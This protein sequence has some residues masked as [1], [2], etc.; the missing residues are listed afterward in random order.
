[1]VSFGLLDQTSK[2]L[3]GDLA[4][5]E[6]PYEDEVGRVFDFHA[7][8]GQCATLLA[9]SGV[10]MKTAQTIL[11]HKDINSTANVYTHVLRGQEAQAVASMPDLSC[12]ALEAEAVRTGTDSRV[13]GESLFGARTIVDDS[14]R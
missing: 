10:N 1:M 2:M 11:R 7:L 5:A 4:R 8:R 13:V 3:R 12:S 6:I 9:L 14:E